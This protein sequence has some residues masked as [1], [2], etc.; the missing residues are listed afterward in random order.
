MIAGPNHGT[1]V[2]LPSALGETLFDPVQ[3][4]CLLELPVG[5]PAMLYQ[6]ELDSDFETALN[7][8]DETPGDIDYTAHYTLTDELVQPAALDYEQDDLRVSNILWQ[9]VCP[10]HLSDH[11]LVGTADSLAFALALDAISQPR[12]ADIERAGAPPNAVACCRSTRPRA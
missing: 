8:G 9:E 6:F 3:L 7:A 11:F 1:A 10:G 2:A 4:D 12:P 5:I